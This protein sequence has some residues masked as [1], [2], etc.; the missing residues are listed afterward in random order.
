MDGRF[1]TDEFED[2]IRE[3]ADKFYL[4]PSERVWNGIYNNLRPGSKWPSLGM[5]LVILISLV[6]IG[7][8]HQ[9]QIKE[10][11]LQAEAQ[12]N[13]QLTVGGPIVPQTANLNSKAKDYAERPSAGMVLS[14]PAPADNRSKNNQAALA[15][16][17]AVPS[18]PQD[19]NSDMRPNL[20]VE[21][22][23]TVP[24]AH[25]PVKAS[26]V[27]VPVNESEGKD[28]IPSLPVTDKGISQADDSRGIADLTASGVSDGVMPELPETKK[29]ALSRLV[30]EATV[31][32]VGITGAAATKKPAAKVRKAQWEFFVA[33][34]VANAHL[35]KIDIQAPQS[36]SLLANS[37]IVGFDIS[38]RS[39]A[40]IQGG[41]DAI[42][43][44]NDVLAARTG[45]HIAYSGYKIKADFVHPTF[46]TVTFVNREGALSNKSYMTYYG[47]KG[48][49]GKMNLNNFRLTLSVPLGVDWKVYENDNVR[50]IVMSA[51]EPLALLD[52][53]SFVVSSDTRNFVEDP[54]LLRRFNV[55]GN[56]GTLINFKGSR[57]NWSMGPV[58]SYQILSSY[59]NTYPV[60]EHLVNYGFRIGVKK[61]R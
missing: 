26:E 45:A 39:L 57:V 13:K 55:N 1:D 33:P 41:A 43:K 9:P 17:V 29:I 47:N 27:S 18:L 3:Q 12:N 50:V 28:N 51:V 42:Y 58:F 40:G 54:D 2:L 32:A 60:R 36:Q 38:K 6:W 15:E 16:R 37:N 30:S 23:E 20:A 5:G 14:K 21:N 48:N 8:S 19:D 22:A 11:A 35:D 25:K 52:A 4:V 24:D 31:A 7:S 56:I 10:N 46:A 59:Q 34:V 49:A 61:S 53:N 44:I